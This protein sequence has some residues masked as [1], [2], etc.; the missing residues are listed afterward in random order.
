MSIFSLFYGEVKSELNTYEHG[1]TLQE[2]VT[3]LFGSVEAAVARGVTV[4]HDEWSTLITHAPA[5]AAPVAEATPAPAIES[6]PVAEVV[7]APPAQ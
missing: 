6:T 3:S 4:V 5:A 7:E 2:F 1:G